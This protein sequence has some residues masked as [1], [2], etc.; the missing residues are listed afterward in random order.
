M[1][2][3]ML[4]GNWPGNFRRSVRDEQGKVLKVLEF[5]P[6]VPVEVNDEELA[7]ITPDIGVCI[8][9]VQCDDKGRPRIVED[10]VE[11]A[12]EPAADEPTEKTADES[13][14]D[15]D[16][17]K[18]VRDAGVPGPICEALQDAGLDELDQLAAYLHAGNAYTDIKGIGPKSAEVLER[19]L[20][21]YAA[22]LEAVSHQ[23]S[24]SER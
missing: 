18:T 15:Q 20:N 16:G 9:H 23:P 5:T 4:K 17:P 6:G 8:V 22:S 12:D 7:A 21:E 14:D 1:Y 13:E 3:V 11:V 19:H 24:A 10:P 2:S